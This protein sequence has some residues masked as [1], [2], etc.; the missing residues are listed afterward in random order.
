VHRV[1]LKINQTLSEIFGINS[2]VCRNGAYS[3]LFDAMLFYNA[4]TWT[5][6][7]M[8]FQASLPLAQSKIKFLIKK[9]VDQSGLP[10][11]SLPKSQ[12]FRGGDSAAA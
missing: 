12:P 5:E 2:D 4:N 9:V 10:F 8:I 6:R 1:R 3:C 7:Q 11:S